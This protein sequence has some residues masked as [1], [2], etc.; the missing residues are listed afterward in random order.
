MI[1]VMHAADWVGGDGTTGGVGIA[2]S[3]D[4][5]EAHRLLPWPLPPEW[6]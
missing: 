2:T 6:S 3:G 4:H 5:L 1:Q